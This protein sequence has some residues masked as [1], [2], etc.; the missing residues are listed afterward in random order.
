[1]RA[2]AAGVSREYLGYF[3]S[4]GGKLALLAVAGG[5]QSFAYVP[6]A[7]IVRQVFD[8]IL[9][10]HDTRGLWI[11]VGELLVLQAAGLALAYWT[12]MIA[13]R[14]NQD[15][16]AQL[17]ER[18]IARL[19][20]LPRSFH[21]LSDHDR[22]HV[23]LVYETNWV[24][25][26]N[27][28]LTAQ[29]LPAAL[30]A[31]ALFFVMFWI[32]PRYAWIVAVA[33]PALAVIN[34]LVTR[35]AWLRRHA[36][37]QAF[38]NF[39]RGVRFLLS[40][41]DLTRAQAAEKL[42][43]NRQRANIGKLRE[44]SLD[45]NRFDAIQQLFQA[46]L[47]LAATLCVLLAGGYAVAQGWV[48]GGE[49]MAFYVAAALFATQARTMVGA[50][51]DLRMGIRALREIQAVI[52]RPE[53][54]PYG[55]A[56]RVE[57]IE[58]IRLEHVS[59]RYLDD[60]PVLEDASLEIARGAL[61]A[62]AGTNGAGKTSIAHLIGG[63]Y[64]PQRGRVSANGA[65]Y[66]ELDIRSLRA[67]V[68]V[69]PQNPLLFSGTIRENVTYGVE[70]PAERD[71]EQALEWAGA[72]EFIGEL[73]EGIETAIG[74][75]GV[76]LSG[77]Q[78]QRLAIAR[79]LLRRPDLLILDEPTSH[80]DEEGIAH[81]MAALGALPF[82]PA[83]LLISHELRVLRHVDSA[84]RLVDGRLEPLALEVAR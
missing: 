78:R 16:L 20:D 14:I 28:A 35:E 77:G 61:I 72:R 69:A 42:E 73:P 34:R 31:A 58:E 1:M 4:H 56:R 53:R 17:R 24:E 67:R 3:R 38:E 60:Q 45:L 75:N 39:S 2:P 46:A 11:A 47:L 82:R 22:L 40:A 62:L 19:Y 50:V 32:E 49:M 44:I 26:M 59:F 10:A 76:R 21:T 18:S 84:C 70:R 8:R 29:F 33:A 52:A 23:T 27:N 43:L 55:G 13:L 68:A 64:R 79:A 37:R 57:R 65:A 5:L 36:L 80:L 12:R 30:A 54:E 71:V 66:D 74:E 41:I 48:T 7:A 6:L 63:Y 15:V 51:P 9:P 81:L 25:A 83:I